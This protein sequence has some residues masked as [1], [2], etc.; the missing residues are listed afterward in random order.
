MPM[1]SRVTF[2]LKDCILEFEDSDKN[3]IQIKNV[4]IFVDNG[5]GYPFEH[6]MDRSLLPFDVRATLPHWYSS[7][8]LS[9]PV[10]YRLLFPGKMG[11]NI[12]FP[13]FITI[14]EVNKSEDTRI[15][16]GDSNYFI[17]NNA[18]EEK[19]SNLYQT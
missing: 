17:L 4:S 7:E 6:N 15:N 16:I 14:K 19:I 13:G 18:E 8:D 12:S 10:P 11:N 2:S 5:C 9:Y 1:D 3:S